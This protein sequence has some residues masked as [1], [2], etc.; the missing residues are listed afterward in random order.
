[1]IFT[2]FGHIACYALLLAGFTFCGASSDRKNTETIVVQNSGVDESLTESSKDINLINT[3]YDK[4]VFATD[5]DGDTNPETYFT[6]NALKKLQDD[7]EFDCDEGPCYAYYA[8]R[9]NAQDSKPGS[10]ETSRIYSIEP[11]RDGWYIVSFSDMGWP[12][13]T[14]IRIVDRK[15]DCYERQ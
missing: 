11:V 12:G 13:K 3:V 8:L 5:S 15:I 10:D 2:C 9:T 1:M 6:S 4:F 14:R 7:Y